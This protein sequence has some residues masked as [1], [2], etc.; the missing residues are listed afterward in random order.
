MT[1]DHTSVEALKQRAEEI[2]WHIEEAVPEKGG[3]SIYSV[4]NGEHGM[5]VV[6]DDL[7]D[8]IRDLETV[9]EISKGDPNRL[10]RIIEWMTEAP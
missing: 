3:L 6:T 4:V 2:G 5:Y 7:A 10:S 1:Y 8:L 9:T